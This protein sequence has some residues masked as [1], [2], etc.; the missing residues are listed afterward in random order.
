MSQINALAVIAGMARAA[1]GP[2]FSV[3]SLCEASAVAGAKQSLFTVQAPAG[4]PEHL[5]T[6]IWSRLFESEDSIFGGSAFYG[7]L[8]LSP[9]CAAF[10]A[11]VEFRLFTLI[12]FG[13]SPTT[14]LFLWPGKSACLI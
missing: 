6:R 11:N 3:S 4:K 8:P 7:L 12:Q 1:G 2:T 10:A 13:A 5:P 9:L 14:P